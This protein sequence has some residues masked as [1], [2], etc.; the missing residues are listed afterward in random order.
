LSRV[1]VQ[2]QGVGADRLGQALERVDAQHRR[3]G[4]ADVPHHHRAG[5]HRPHREGRGQL[6]ALGHRALAADAEGHAELLGHLSE[7]AVDLARALG[8][9]GHARHPERGLQGLAEQPHRE[10]DLIGRELRHGAVHQADLI[11]QRRVLARRDLLGGAQ[12]E[13]CVLPLRCGVVAH[14]RFAG[15]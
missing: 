9:A 13:V 3:L 11:E 1:Q 14:F 10:I 7:L 15:S 12:V 4:Q 8:A 2:R 5:R 6:G